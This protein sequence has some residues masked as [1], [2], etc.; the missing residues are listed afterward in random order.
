MAPARTSTRRTQHDQSSAAQPAGH[1]DGNG[2]INDDLFLE[3]M[4]GTPLAIYVE[5]DVED[6]DTIV[7]M[8]TVSRV[9]VLGIWTCSLH[10]EY[11]AM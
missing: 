1:D 5:K 6:R 3:P 11:P 2:Q 9:K 8:I 10:Q 7:T 4:M